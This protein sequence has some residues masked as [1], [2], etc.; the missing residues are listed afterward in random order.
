[1]TLLSTL[2]GRAGGGTGLGVTRKL[3][4]EPP[5]RMPLSGITGNFT[6]SG[7]GTNE[8][9]RAIACGEPVQ[10]L[11]N[12]AVASVGTVGSLSDHEWDFADNDTIGDTRIYVRD[13]SGDPDGLDYALWEMDFW[14]VALT[15]VTFGGLLEQGACIAFDNSEDQYVVLNMGIVPDETTWNVSFLVRASN[16]AL[17]DTLTFIG[18]YSY[19]HDGSR[20]TKPASLT[21]ITSTKAIGDDGAVSKVTLTGNISA[22]GSIAAGDHLKLCVAWDQSEGTPIETPILAECPEGWFA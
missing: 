9:Y 2:I 4:W 15:P 3:R 10:V 11:Y 5:T 16:T 18:K 20:W 6:A 17:S 19:A 7:G 8:Y 1:M 13:D 22:L 21:M 14:G 12:G